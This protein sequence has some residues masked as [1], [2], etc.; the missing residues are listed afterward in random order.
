M[1]FSVSSIFTS[2]R[3]IITGKKAKTDAELVMRIRAGDVNA[4]ECI[5]RRHNQRLFRIARSIL[6]DEH[7]AM[8]AVQDTYIKAYYQIAQFKGPEGFISWLSRIVSNE[9]LTRLRNAKQ[10]SYGLDEKILEDNANAIS[11]EPEALDILANHQLR[12]ILENEIDKLSV[13]YR[14]VYVMRAIQQLSTQETALILNISVDN[15][16]TRYLRAKRILQ[17]GLKVHLKEAE[18]EV[19][20]FAGHRCDFIVSSVLSKIN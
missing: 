16:K 9:A 6:K 8:D 20:E 12:K 5:M 19:F 11:V 18:L 13:E 10:L 17:H 14:S 4:L 7:E 2:P 1:T 15:V 3:T